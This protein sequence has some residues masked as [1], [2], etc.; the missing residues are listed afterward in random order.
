MIFDAAYLVALAFKSLA[1]QTVA[2]PPLP[3]LWMTRDLC[4]PESRA[5]E[6]DDIR[7]IGIR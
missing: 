4:R 1:S 7:R 2:N 3:S 5:G 6:Q